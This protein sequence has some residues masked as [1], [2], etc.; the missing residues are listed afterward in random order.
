ME[1][2]TESRSPFL[3]SLP[4][5]PSLG[6]KKREIGT[7]SAGVLFSV[8][9][10]VF[11]DAIVLSTTVKD[12][13]VSIGIEDY[14]SG[15]ICTI[16]MIIVNS[17]DLTIL[18]G[19]SF[20]YSGSGL[21]GK[22]RMF[23]FLGMACMAGGV[24]GSVAILCIKYLV[25]KVTGPYLYFGVAPIVQNVTILISC[26]ILWISQNVESEAQYNFVLN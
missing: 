11:V 13:P 5:L 19:E 1:E 2:W 8:A 12:L 14:V 4:R 17:I 22:A 9:W 16:G 25:P 3:C 23:L 6:P 26:A 7:Y 10:W 20:S 24:A 15:I 18:Q 21:A